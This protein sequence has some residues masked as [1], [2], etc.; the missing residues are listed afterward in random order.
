MLHS[1]VSFIKQDSALISSYS[2]QLA[3]LRFDE[4]EVRH[5]SSVSGSVCSERAGEGN[6]LN[7][8]A[9]LV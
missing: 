5:M 2:V 8:S 1:K 6:L 4:F 9:L 3:Q 7:G